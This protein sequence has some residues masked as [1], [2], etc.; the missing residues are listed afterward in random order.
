M[1]HN[2]L[3]HMRTRL[4]QMGGVAQQERMIAQKKKSLDKAI[5]YSYQG[6]KVRLLG[7]E[8]EYP[9][10]MNPNQVK[11][12]Y[13]DKILSIGFEY[14]GF[15]PG[16][17]FE[18]V[19]TNTK[20]LIY[21]QDLTELAYFKG[22]VRKCTYEISWIDGEGQ[23]HQTFAALRGPKETSISSITKN[24][25]NIDLPNYTLYF[26]IPRTD[27]TA[28]FF[29]RYAKFYLRDAL[30]PNEQICWR[31][32]GVDSITNPGIIEV[33]ATEYYSNVIEDKDGEAGGA[34]PP[35]PAPEPSSI[36]GPDKIKP[37][38][39]YQFVCEEEATEYNWKL[40]NNLPLSW[41]IDNNILELTW[42]AN[43]SDSFTISCNEI[44]KEITVKS[45]F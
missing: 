41:K 12:D 32:E 34:I 44:N 7:A 42:K 10:L 40:P 30:S 6:A 23:S 20:W 28:K 17:I 43:Y 14:P 35:E 8:E 16:A 25:I 4:N 29:T 21:L 9:A 1:G 11:Q 26:M 3:A 39:T 18:W 45:L 31:V 36:E 15:A 27:E 33:Y 38:I 2:G 22:D 5:S 19:N 24:G 37:H 13:D